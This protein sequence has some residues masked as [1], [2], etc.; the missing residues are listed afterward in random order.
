MLNPVFVFFLF[1]TL[2]IIIILLFAIAEICDQN[3][4]ENTKIKKILKRIINETI[5]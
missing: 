1:A 2:I 3:R 5:D 4:K